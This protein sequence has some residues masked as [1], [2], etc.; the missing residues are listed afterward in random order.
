MSRRIQVDN[1]YNA[2][3]KI[4]QSYEKWAS[5]FGLTLNEMQIYYEIM[6]SQ[7]ETITQKKLCEA[8]EAP[9]T[10]VNSIIKKQMT[11]GLIS[12]QVNPQNKRE[13]VISL[14]EEGKLFAKEVI[15][16]L[17]QYE[18]DIMTQFKEK[19]INMIIDIQNQFADMLLMKVR[20]TNE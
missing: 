2:I 9:K 1:M 13:K 18:E 19:D 17:F 12:L 3:R 4:N 15:L 7:Q 10:S 14:T 16:P 6:D 5:R 20:D 8:L 11:M